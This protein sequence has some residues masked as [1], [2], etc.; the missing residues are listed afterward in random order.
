MHTPSKTV[1]DSEDKLASAAAI[2]AGLKALGHP[3]RLQILRRL[4]C[5]SDCLCADLC[6]RMPLAQSTVSQHLKILREAGLVRLRQVGPRSHYS[7]VPERL[8]EMLEALT[9]IRCLAKGD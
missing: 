8:D 2:A 1:A 6:E 4:C 9:S 3:A 5:E 7:L